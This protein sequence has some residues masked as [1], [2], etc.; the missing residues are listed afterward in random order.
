MKTLLLHINDDDAMESRLQA[1]LD[2]ARANEGHIICHQSLS[3]EVFTPGDFYG[4]AIA[5]AMPVI[6]ESADKL[7]EKIEGELANEDVSWEWEL[8]YGTDANQLLARSPLT[9]LI[10]V[11]PTDTGSEGKR[12]SYTAGFLAL[13]GRTPVMVVP[14]DL[15]RFDTGAPA[16]VAWNG[17]SEACNALRESLSLL[18]SAS[19]V[20]LG[21]V[22][23]AKDKERYDFPPLDGAEYLGRQDIKAEIIEMPPLEGGIGATL[24]E[25]AQAREC[26]VMV[27]G[28]YGHSRLS[29]LLL[30]GVTRAILKDPKLPIVLAH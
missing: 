1:A 26:G 21:C 19:T 4:S 14:S 16:M 28:A 7:R 17:S 29:E 30:G 2:I 18:R 11:G 20:Y 12:A 25:A 9:D 6:R 5:A 10:L 24:F 22:T 23:E 27:M 15:K 3:Y 13:H 8:D